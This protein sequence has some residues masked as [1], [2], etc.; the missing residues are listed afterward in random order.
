MPTPVPSSLPR[1]QYP[2][3]SLL[4]TLMIALTASAQSQI[5]TGTIRGTVLGA[6]G[7]VVAG[8]NVEIKNVDTNISR[9]LS[10]NEE[11][12]FIA[13]Q[14]QPGRYS[15]TIAKQGFA[16]TQD[17]NVTLTVGQTLDLSFSLKISNVQETV[18]V[19]AA[20]TVDTAKT[21]VSTTLN[22]T[23]VSTTPVSLRIRISSQPPGRY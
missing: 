4:L 20:P 13:P 23:A 5:T 18:T 1:L 10:T 7:A 11:G 2:I 6:N 12:S 17:P 8:A 21:E 14:L 9:N 16:T 3:V 22:E 15:V 19:T